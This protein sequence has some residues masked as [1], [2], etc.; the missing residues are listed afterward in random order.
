MSAYGG[1]LGPLRAGPLLGYREAARLISINCDD[2]GMAPE[3]NEATLAA[4]RAGRATSATLI[5]PA[6]H[7]EAAAHAGQGQPIGIHLA[8]NSE[9]A[10]DRWQPLTAASSLRDDDGWLCRTPQ[11]TLARA[12]AHDVR[13][14]WRAQIEQAIA[15]GIDVTHL[16]SHMYIAQE[17]PDFFAIYLD[18]ALEYRLP[19]RISGSADQPDHPFRALARARG[20]VCPD[21]LVKLR[22]VGSRAD[23]T[24][25]LA[26]LPSGVTEFHLH[27]AV[28]TASLRRLASDWPGRV[29]DAALLRE[30]G[31]WRR[32]T[33]AG[34]T[35]VSYRDLRDAFRQVTATL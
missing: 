10:A 11:E 15:W 17:R 1:G 25:A 30:D 22:Q 35:L 20:V 27:P 16:D 29:D 24:A 7:A 5:V 14:E 8:L 6:T 33:A 4:L 18:L 2:L 32:V 3:E 23:L 34:A 9:W 28:D 13:V 12:T 31:F 19:V 21:H 26:D